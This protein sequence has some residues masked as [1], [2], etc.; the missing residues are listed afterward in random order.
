M[1][2]LVLFYLIVL[3]HYDIAS[4]DESKETLVTIPSLG[5]VRG[6]LMNSVGGRQFLAFRGIPYA[7]PP[8]GN[9]RF[10]VNHNSPGPHS[11][12]Q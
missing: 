5:Q 11:S 2:L 8:I 3:A 1:K 12:L 10:K 6:S 9:L 4:G 7:K